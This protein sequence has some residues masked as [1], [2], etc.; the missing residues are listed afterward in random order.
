MN[1]TTFFRRELP[2]GVRL[3]GETVPGRLSTALGLWFRVGSRDE[4]TGREG[5]AHFIEHLVFKGTRRR[6]GREIASSLERVGGSL[7]AFTTKETTCYYA[8]VLEQDT[9]LAADVLADLVARPRFDPEDVELERRVVLEELMSVEDAPEDL[10]GDLAFTHLWPDHV[11][12]ASILGTRDSL[13]ALSAAEVAAFHAREYRLPRVVVSAA[14]AVD[15]DRLEVLF[16]DALE[17]GGAP[18]IPERTAPVAAP[19]TFALHPADL[20]QLHLALAV[21]SCAEN[22]PRRRAVHLLAEIFG[23]GMSSRLFQTIREEAGLAYSVYAYSEHFEDSGMFGIA[24]AVSPRAGKEALARTVEEMERMRRDG[25]QPGELDA[26][27]AQ[28]RGSVIMGLESLTNR[29]GRLAR[30]ELRLGAEEPVER[31]IAEY[32]AVTEQ[33]VA[34][35]AGELLD[36][37]LQTLVALGP[38]DGNGLRYKSFARELEQEL[39]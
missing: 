10:I 13:T 36:P 9:A 18:G 37:A 6:S 26:A 28:V 16:R 20:S 27:K 14:G 4:E 32:E 3:V 33:D 19:S 11:M 15:P 21:P 24:L 38:A 34:E 8:R 22:D 35:A 17:L 7:D 1:D 29:M 39:P 23:G 25:L 31:V 12:G 30:A 5:V 2:G